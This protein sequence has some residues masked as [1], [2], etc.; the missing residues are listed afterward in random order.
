MLTNFLAKLSEDTELLE[1]YKKDPK[2]EMKKFGLSD[3]DI[4]VVLSGDVNAIKQI[5]GSK[6]QDIHVL[7][8]FKSD[9][10]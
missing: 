3:T 6:T 8:I 5:H 4:E 10:K 9:E 1:A 2:G 7:F